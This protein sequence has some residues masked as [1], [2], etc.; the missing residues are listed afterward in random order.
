MSRQSDNPHES[1]IRELAGGLTPVKRLPSPT[2]RTLAWIA[3]VALIGVCGAA[4]ADLQALNARLSA[5]PDMWLAAAGSTLTAVFAAF[6]TFQ[7]S[8]PD[9]S[10]RWAW[11]PVPAAILWIAASGLGCLRTWLVPG[12]HTPG[13]NEERDCLLI[14]VALSLP[15][16]AVLIVMLRKAY[17]LEPELT[18]LTA[19]LA[20]AAAA[21]TLLNLFH[22]FD[23]TA[24]DLAF[25]AVAVL[26]VVAIIRWLGARALVNDKKIY[27]T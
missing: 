19:G 22:P 10:K 26:M 12:T 1:L 8:M 4:I 13:L 21:A 6:A 27:R 5:A 17:V 11:L 20:A 15:L 14:I 16:S 7:L 25:H 3:V 18:A 23:A 2:R 24:S 9:R